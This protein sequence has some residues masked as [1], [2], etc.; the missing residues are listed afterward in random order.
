MP[1]SLDLEIL[2]ADGG[3]IADGYARSR[4]AATLKMYDGRTVRFRLTAPKRTARQNS[5]W[6]MYLDLIRRALIDSGEDGWLDRAAGC[7]TL[8]RHFVE[9]H[10][11]VE[12]IE[13]F[14]NV[15]TR[16]VSTRKLD[17]QTFSNFI[18]AVRLDEDVLRLC[19]ELPSVEQYEQREGPMRSYAFA[20]PDYA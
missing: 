5:F 17:R 13:V 19:V 14:G 4:I 15:V 10:L 8:H 6:W 2:V 18:E 16:P 9:K 3:Q 7:K 20:E 11:G 1:Q 12:T